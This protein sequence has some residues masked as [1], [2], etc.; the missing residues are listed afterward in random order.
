MTISRT[1]G[2]YG[3][4]IA[5]KLS[6]ILSIP[7]IDKETTYAEWLPE[8]TDE[9]AVHMLRSS[10]AFYHH[11]FNQ[12]DTYKDYIANR[13]RSTLSTGPKI[14]LGMGSQVIFKDYP[15]T[16][17]IRINAPFSVRLERMQESWHLST[18]KATANLLE[19]DSRR[20]KFIRKVH[21]QDWE[22]EFLY[23][24]KIN[25]T[26]IGIDESC[27]L[28]RTLISKADRL[29][30]Y[31]AGQLSLFQNETSRYD[32][33][34]EVEGEFAAILDSYGIDWEYEPTT[35]PLTFDDEGNITQAISPDFYLK[36]EDTY[37]ELTVMNPKYMAEKR[38]KVERLRELYPEIK[39]ILM[40]K[41]G[42]ES[43]IQRYKLKTHVEA[44]Q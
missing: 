23:D 13:L 5:K 9:H 6:Q 36:Q 40:D 3:D 1:L 4:E 34:H 29:S 25:T 21:G 30:P 20:K 28:I 17:H 39:V 38:R 44:D 8:V 18:D 31:N 12:E 41:K 27:K 42:L 11:A 26:K 43:F 15:S 7:I 16:V 37:I 22:D 14:F 35:F 24:L 19:S 2:S 33:R 10:Y 32:F